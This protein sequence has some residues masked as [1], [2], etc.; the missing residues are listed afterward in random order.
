VD[1]AVAAGAT[2]V[3][4][5]KPRP[6]LGSELFFEPTVLTGV[7]R[8]M[9]INREETFGPVTPILSFRDDDEAMSLA[10]DSEYGL[11][12]GV[13]TRDMDRALRFAEAI[14]AG[15]VN[16]NDSTTYWEIHLPFGGGSGTHS[17]VGRLGGRLTL[18]AMTEIKMIT[19]TRAI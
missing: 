8:E 12:V 6:D 10:L 4:G 7:T 9:R 13:F 5:G 14:P 1:D 2:V 11:S 16:I 15:I 17:G 19:V 3:T 18:E